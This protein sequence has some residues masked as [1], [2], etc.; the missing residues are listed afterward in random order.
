MKEKQPVGKYI[1]LFL[2]WLLAL[3][4]Q[5]QPVVSYLVSWL[6]TIMIFTLTLSGWVKPLP[7]DRAVA[8]QLMRPIFLVQVIFAGYMSFSSIFYFLN[9]FGFENFHR[10]TNAVFLLDTTKL[11]LAAQ[12]QRYYVLGHAAFITGILVFMKYPVKKKYYVE[13]ETI[14]NLLLYVALITLPLSYIFSTTAGL[15]QFYYQFSSLS[16][17]AGTLALAFA[18]PLKK[19]GNTVIC[20][21]LY[22]SNFYAALISG[23]KEPII[24]SVLILGVFL[25]PT[26]KKIVVFTFIPALL[27]LFVVLPK[28]NNAFR[29]SVWADNTNLDDAYKVAFNAT[30]ESDQSDKEN[31]W[32][33]LVFRLSEIDMFTQFVQSTPT[34]IDFYGVKIL[35]QSLVALVP[36]QFWPSKPS[37]EAVVME[38]VFDAGAVGRL[39]N[40]SAKPTFIVDSYLTGGPISIFICLFL[41]GAIAQSISLKAEFLFGGYILGTALIFSGLFQIFWRGLS[42]EFITNTVFWS[43]ITMLIIFRILKATGTIKEYTPASKKEY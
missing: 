9:L 11:E 43:Y 18:I 26:Y 31:N 34:Y 7:N 13:T 12:C 35:Q 20:A 41:Y 3:G 42:F 27:L 36:R 30:I 23:F 6:G 14:A 29:Q 2:P 15:A 10:E 32:S 1:I 40:V 38:R 25:Y 28:F 33:F 37:T 21:F 5:S 19:A 24:L 17:V 16:F 22:F 4:F 8:E 39:S